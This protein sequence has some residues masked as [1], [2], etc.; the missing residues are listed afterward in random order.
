MTNHE[1][2]DA[3][4]RLSDPIVTGYRTDL[5]DIDAKLICLC[6]VPGCRPFLHFSRSNGTHLEWLYSATDEALPPKGEEVPFLFSTANR[7][8]IVRSTLI[9]VQSILRSFGDVKLALHYDGQRVEQV[10]FEKAL[11]I[12]R[13]NVQSILST[14][15]PARHHYVY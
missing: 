7:E 8:H 2:Y 4:F 11:D 3:V 12:A 1:V 10:S 5:C 9:S 14:W 6:P 13:A 15:E